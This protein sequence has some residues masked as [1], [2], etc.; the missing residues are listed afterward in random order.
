MNADLDVDLVFVGSYALF[1]VPFCHRYNRNR[2]LWRN[3]YWSQVRFLH[4]LRCWLLILGNAA[5]HPLQLLQI[6]PLRLLQIPRES[7]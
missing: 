6:N 2:S 5:S 3:A 4:V 1:F 7:E